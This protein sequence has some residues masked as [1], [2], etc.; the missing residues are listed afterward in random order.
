MIMC[1][2]KAMKCIRRV[3]GRRK[4]VALNGELMKEVERFSCIG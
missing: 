1:K 3:D 2:S 4:N